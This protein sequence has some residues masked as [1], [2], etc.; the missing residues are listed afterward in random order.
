MCI[1]HKSSEAVLNEHH[2]RLDKHITE[3]ELPADY[4]LVSLLLATA[5][6]TAASASCIHATKSELLSHSQAHS[7]LQSQPTN[8]RDKT[9]F[10]PSF[11][12]SGAGSS[13]ANSCRPR[14]KAEGICQLNSPATRAGRMALSEVATASHTLGRASAASFILL[15]ALT[16]C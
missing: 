4:L 6:P 15:R 8:Q 10:R 1:S 12:S 11:G 3:D 7:H 16:S 13:I 5:S 9:H 14:S 2:D